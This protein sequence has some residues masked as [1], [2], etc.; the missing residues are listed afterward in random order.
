M[1]DFEKT[2]LPK[3]VP[4]EVMKEVYERIKTPYKWGPVVKFERELCDSPA[5][6]RYNGKWYMS[7]IKID[8]DV[9]SSG[10]DSHLAV[11]DDLLHWEYLYL[12]NFPMMFLCAA[13]LF[14]QK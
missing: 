2:D 9:K 11:S 6:F 8:K 13:F 1:I 3:I 12:S 7:F 14:H 10:Y 4:D 5:V